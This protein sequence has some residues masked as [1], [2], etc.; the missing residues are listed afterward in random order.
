MDRPI[1]PDAGKVFAVPLVE[2]AS[3]IGVEADLSKSFAEQFVLRMQGGV[4]DAELA[5]QWAAALG[6]VEFFVQAV[7][8]VDDGPLRVQGWR[9]R[10]G[11]AGE[12]R[13]ALLEN[14]GIAD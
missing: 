12:E 10:Q 14:P 2:N 13:P 6:A 4:F 11:K 5:H 3:P 7:M 1:R 9:R 8:L